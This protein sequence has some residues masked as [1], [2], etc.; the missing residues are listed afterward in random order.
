MSNRETWLLSAVDKLRPW[1]P[2]H[3]VTVPDVVRVS[4]GFPSR[5]VRKT[6]GECWC[7]GDAAGNQQI[8]ITPTLVDPSRVLDVLVHELAHAALPPKVK[9]GK[10]FAV[11]ARALGLEGKPTHTTAG[12]ILSHRLA[13][14]SEEL[15][16]YP[17][18]ALTLATRIAQGTRMLKTICPACGY[19]VRVT[20]KWRDVGVPTCPCGTEMRHV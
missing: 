12:P 5:S 9:H 16:P 15:G 1:Y 6:L 19:T 13:R 18:A 11:L 8:F 4:C 20:A 10:R 7:T 3:G 2:E 14:L 17:H